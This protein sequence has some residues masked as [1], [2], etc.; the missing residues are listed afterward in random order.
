MRV[1]LFSTLSGCAPQ[2]RQPPPT[3][4]GTSHSADVRQASRQAHLE[5]LECSCALG[6]FLYFP[7]GARIATPFPA[8]AAVLFL[9]FP[10]RAGDAKRGE[11][12]LTRGPHQTERSSAHITEVL[13]KRSSQ[14]ER[15]SASP[16]QRKEL[17]SLQRHADAMAG[18]LPFACA[19][20]PWRMGAASD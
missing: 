7:A 12:V 19:R 6:W 15:E 4:A 3:C 8:A 5:H 9:Y 10:S 17:D 16:L 13:T 14:Q 11:E 18:Q 1:S 2:R 20:A